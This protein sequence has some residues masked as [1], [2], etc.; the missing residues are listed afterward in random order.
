[1]YILYMCAMCPSVQV[2]VHLSLVHQ[3]TFVARAHVARLAPSSSSSTSTSK[4]RHFLTLLS[5]VSCCA[6]AR[7]GY[8]GTF[9]RV[10]HTFAFSIVF[11][12]RFRW[13]PNFFSFGEFHRPSVLFSSCSTFCFSIC[14]QTT[15][16]LPYL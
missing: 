9:N 4:S 13:G 15:I 1:M 11:A 8:T 12:F 2:F 3:C 14:W 5:A 6:R 7:T 10:G 16:L